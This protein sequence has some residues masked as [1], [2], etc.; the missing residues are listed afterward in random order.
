MGIYNSQFS[1][2]VIA[3][4]SCHYVSITLNREFM[5]FFFPLVVI[6]PPVAQKTV[7]EASSISLQP[8]SQT[9]SSANQV[10]VNTAHIVNIL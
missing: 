1:C 5:S 6:N 10:K 2:I 7:G 3:P 4:M 8:E 9:S